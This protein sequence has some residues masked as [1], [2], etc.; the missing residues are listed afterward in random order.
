ML[1]ASAVVVGHPHLAGLAIVGSYGTATPRPS[2]ADAVPSMEAGSQVGC[3][4]SIES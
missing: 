3:V 2:L 1:W 4:G